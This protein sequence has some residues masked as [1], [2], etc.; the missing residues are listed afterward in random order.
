MRQITF[1]EIGHVGQPKKGQA[2]ELQSGTM[3]VADNDW[4]PFNPTEYP[5]FK[6]TEWPGV[7]S[8]NHLISIRIAA[9]HVI[10]QC[11]FLERDMVSRTCVDTA[12]NELV[13]ILSCQ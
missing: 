5:I 3:L 13:A 7:I 6:R 11:A 4:S 8:N 2:I 1:I 9:E 12:I 10:N